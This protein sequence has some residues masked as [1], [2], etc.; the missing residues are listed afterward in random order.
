MTFRSRVVAVLLFLSLMSVVTTLTESDNKE[1]AIKIQDHVASIHQRVT[2]GRGLRLWDDLFVAIVKNYD[3]IKMIVGK[4]EKGVKVVETS[5]DKTVVTL[6]HAHAEVVSQFVANGFD[7]AHKNHPVPAVVPALPKLEFPIIPKHGGV[8]PRPKSVEQPRAVAKV[9]FDATADAKPA[10]VNKGLDRVARLLNLYGVAGLKTQDVNITI[11]LHGE[12]TKSVLNDAAYKTL[13]R[14]DENPNLPLIRELQ[15]AGVEVYLC[16]QALNYKGFADGN[17]ANGI[18]I[19]ADA[20]TVVVNKHSDG[21]SYIP[22][23]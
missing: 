2:N 22:D 8:L 5:D 11:V 20:L 16:G 17:V 9:V 6:I 4:T 18:P 1:V 21:Y 3:K 15:K 7:E 12:A 23:P 19:G 14:V 13:F 10:D